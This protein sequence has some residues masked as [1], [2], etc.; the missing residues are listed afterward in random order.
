MGSPRFRSVATEGLRVTDAAF[1]P[2]DTLSMHRH[3]SAILAVMLD[4][5]FRVAFPS[6]TFDCSAGTV[7]VEP[8]GEPHA[9]HVS[10][11]GARVLVLEIP[12]EMLD[13]LGSRYSDLVTSARAWA[14]PPTVDLARRL[15]TE[16]SC[17]DVVSPLGVEALA[18]E[19][20]ADAALRSA[21]PARPGRHPGWLTRVQEM[22]DDHL[23]SP[24]R[25]A[26]L[27]REVGV[28][29]VHL[30]R[31]FR[32]RFGVSLGEYH[33]RARVRWAAA[34][35]AG[36]DELAANIAMQAGFAD[37]SHFTRVFRRVVGVPPGA[38]RALYREGA[39]ETVAT[40]LTLPWRQGIG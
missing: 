21:P 3:E 1:A 7:F 15:R 9:N 4:G 38:Y 16:L 36:G 8:G 2:G 39:A 13:G 22:L 26:D 37:A 14:Q 25:I 32:R 35:L 18:I 40:A 6:R 5:G 19:L 11:D 12:A 23:E 20:L 10:R 28:H 24:L 27:S 31:A 29:R 30:G 17:R 34:K 33:R